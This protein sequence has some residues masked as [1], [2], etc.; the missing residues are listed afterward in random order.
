MKLVILGATAVLLLSAAPAAQAATVN[1]S[2]AAQ[3]KAA[4]AEGVYIGSANSN[5][6]CHGNNGG[7]DKN[8]CANTWRN[9]KSD[10]GT[11][12]QYAIKITSPSQCKT[13]PNIVHTSNT[14]TKATKGLTN[15][16]VTP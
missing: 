2:T 14:V 9:N 8:G 7:V 16:P 13:N 11:V 12:G 6:S 1:V 4:L 3:L 5:W 10:L 15:V